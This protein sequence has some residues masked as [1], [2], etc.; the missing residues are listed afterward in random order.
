MLTVSKV[1]QSESHLFA[2]AFQVKPVEHPEHVAEYEGAG[3][4]EQALQFAFPVTEAS[5]HARQ[6]V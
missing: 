2:V 1:V 4:F 5:E 3:V 6:L